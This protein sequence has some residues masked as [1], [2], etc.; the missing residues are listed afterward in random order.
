MS[1]NQLADELSAKY[2]AEWYR[3]HPPPTPDE[4]RAERIRMYEKL[5]TEPDEVMRRALLQPWCRLCIEKLISLY[6]DKVLDGT[7]TTWVLMGEVI[8][9]TD[10]RRMP[11]GTIVDRPSIR[12]WSH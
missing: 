4:V 12:A 5:L 3:S 6:K 10:A 7:K 1:L 2:E 11:P 8:E 9:V